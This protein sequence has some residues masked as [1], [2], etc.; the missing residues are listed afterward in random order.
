MVM[1]GKHVHVSSLV[2]PER[3][4]H[5]EFERVIESAPDAIDDC[6]YT[7][8]VEEFSRMRLD[9][10]D[11][12][13]ERVLTPFL[14]TWGGMRRVLGDRGLRVAIEAMKETSR[15]I[16]PLRDKGLS[17]MDLERI[18]KV[19]VDLFDAICNKRFRNKKGRLKTVGSTA[20]SKLLHL[21]CPD[22]FVMWDT[23]IRGGYG[24][25]K[26]DG[27]DYFHF[28][29]QMKGM[30]I[31]L[32]TTI[33]RLAGKYRKSKTKVLDEYNFVTCHRERN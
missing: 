2:D 27:E 6:I 7:R 23:K 26:G 30:I 13:L 29:L 22:L 17:N 32:Q 31:R 33:D 16:E 15:D 21:A 19:I 9:Q 20:A 8:C 3:I 1:S 18:D 25:S 11:E 10:P 4:S 12:S 24:K 5:E 28:L 14:F